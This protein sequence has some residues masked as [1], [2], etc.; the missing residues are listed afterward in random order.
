[1]KDAASQKD[2]L[3]NFTVFF[4]HTTT[5][6]AVAP[7]GKFSTKQRESKR[8]DVTFYCSKLLTIYDQNRRP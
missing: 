7:G 8:E 3:W 4:H 1:M 2:F 6:G 5:K